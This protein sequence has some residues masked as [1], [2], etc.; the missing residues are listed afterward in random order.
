[1]KRALFAN[2]LK[3]VLAFAVITACAYP[4]SSYAFTQWCTGTVT[5]I[6]EYGTG[7]SGAIWIKHP[8]TTG[9][10]CG[11]NC[12]L[13][14]STATDAQKSRMLSVLLAAFLSGRQV[15]LELYWPTGSLQSCGSVP[16]ANPPTV[17]VN[18][19]GIL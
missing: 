13:K 5:E 2:L 14:I 11:S 15:S 7:A 12:W 18:Y 4:R 1:M 16:A 9:T 10:S 8:A 6:L 3:A 17:E 19:V